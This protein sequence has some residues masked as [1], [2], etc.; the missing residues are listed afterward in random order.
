MELKDWL[1]TIGILLTLSVSAI[2]LYINWANRRNGAREYLYK[3]QFEFYK[4]LTNH[5]VEVMGHFNQ[6]KGEDNVTEPQL[7]FISASI[8]KMHSLIVQNAFFIPNSLETQLRKAQKESWDLWDLL[9]T[10]GSLNESDT[11]KISAAFS[12]LMDWIR[13]EIGADK[14]SDENKKLF[15]SVIIKPKKSE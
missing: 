2:S 5:I 9:Y 7:E 14:L 15:G 1:Y 3:E 10:K 11:D 4:K 8:I 6:M 12:E 13:N